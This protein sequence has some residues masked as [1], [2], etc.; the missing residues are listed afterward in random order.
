[1][2]HPP[3]ATH[4]RRVAAITEPGA[5]AWPALRTDD[6]GGFCRDISGTSL[7]FIRRCYPVRTEPIRACPT[8]SQPGP[9]R[10]G[11][12]AWTG[13]AARDDQR[14]TGNGADSHAD[15]DSQSPGPRLGRLLW[16]PPRVLR[17]EFGSSSN[18]WYGTWNVGASAPIG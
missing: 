7:D 17:H 15:R 8:V 11:V 10:Q 2:R 18:R 6:E 1:L 13:E 14:E 5:R 4:L 9:K 12:C 3:D 16:L